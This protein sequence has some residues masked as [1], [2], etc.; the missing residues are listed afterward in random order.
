M[1]TDTDIRYLK[2]QPIYREIRYTGL[3]MASLECTY[4]LTSEPLGVGGV[5]GVGGTLS[6]DCLR[7]ASENWFFRAASATIV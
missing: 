7:N 3:P 4:P 5:V 6:T 1:P 2:I